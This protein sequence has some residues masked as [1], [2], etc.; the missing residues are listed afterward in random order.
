MAELP[1]YAGRATRPA[2]LAGLHSSQ[3]GIGVGIQICDRVEGP[4]SARSAANVRPPSFIWVIA[5]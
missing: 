4:K 3:V 5:A 2:L 1:N